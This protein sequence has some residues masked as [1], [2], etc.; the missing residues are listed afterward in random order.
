MHRVHVECASPAR[1]HEVGT[2]VGPVGG[3]WASVF[4][5]ASSFKSFGAF[6]AKGKPDLPSDSGLSGSRFR[7]DG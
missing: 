5:R 7:R 1:G 3:F 6:R 4:A 2:G